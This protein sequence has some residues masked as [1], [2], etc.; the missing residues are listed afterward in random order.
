MANSEITREANGC[1]IRESWMP[2]NGNSGTSLNY[3]DRTTGKW[4]QLWVGAGGGVLHLTGALEG[5]A[6]IMRGERQ[7]PQGRVMDKISY[8][9]LP[10]GRVSQQWDISTDGGQTWR[11][12][13]LGFYTRRR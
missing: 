9:P 10:D 12:T 4:H 2:R 6:M 3:F 8:T 11:T 7:M 1:A 5:Q 13:F